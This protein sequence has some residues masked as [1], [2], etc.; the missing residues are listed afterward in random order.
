M[1]RDQVYLSHA[2]DA[3]D[4]VLEYSSD[5]KKAFLVDHKTQDAVVRNLEI[6]GEAVKNVS[7]AVREANTEI[8][9]R[10]IAGMRDKVIHEYFGVDLDL[11]WDVVERELPGLK[12]RL[13]EILASFGE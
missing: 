11:V 3:I 5:G 12:K 10:R 1:S 13:E 2:R 8:P 9:W 4:R 6:L 7:A